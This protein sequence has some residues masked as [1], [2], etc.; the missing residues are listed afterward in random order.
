MKFPPSAA[1]ATVLP[2]LARSELA[3]RGSAGATAEIAARDAAPVLTPPGSDAVL[4]A[5]CRRAERRRRTYEAKQGLRGLRLKSVAGARDGA[6]V[7]GD[8]HV[9]ILLMRF[10]DDRRAEL[11]RREEIEA[12]FNRESGFSGTEEIAPDGDDDPAASVGSVSDFFRVNSRDRLRVRATVTDWIDMKKKGR[13]YASNR[14]GAASA[15]LD[16][17]SRFKEGIREALDKLGGG[18]D[19]SP[20]SYLPGGRRHREKQNE[21]VRRP[22]L[23]SRRGVRRGQV[24]DADLE[25]QGEARRDR[26]AAI[27]NLC[28]NLASSASLGPVEK[29][30]LGRAGDEQHRSE[31]LFRH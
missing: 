26:A 4:P 3:L 16:S 15:G 11:P 20:Y 1:L 23:A 17:G 14:G 27:R 28:S 25:P 31:H 30:G 19:F 18:F 10:K 9:L 13:Y 29:R 5:A 22:R 12:L 8:L 2:L 24:P 7:A 6:P 21:D